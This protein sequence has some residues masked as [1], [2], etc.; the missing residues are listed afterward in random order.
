MYLQEILEV[1]IGVIF[2]WMLLSIAVMQIQEIISSFFAKRSSDLELAIRD[3]LNDPEKVNMFYAHPLIKSLAKPK[4]L[5][6]KDEE[7]AKKLENKDNLTFLERRQLSKLRG[8]PSYIPSAN[9]ASAIFDIVTKAGT[10]ESPIRGITRGM[11]DTI[12]KMKD[13]DREKANAI[14][15]GIYQ[16]GQTAAKSNAGIDFQNGVKRELKSR[17][18]RLGKEYNELT[19][20]TDQLKASIDSPQIDLGALFKSDLV[21]DQLRLGTRVLLNENSALGE[22]I[23]SLFSGVEEYAESADK[24]LALGRKNVETWFDNTMERMNGWYKRWALWLAFGI[25]LMIAILFNVDSLYIAQELWR[26]PAARLASA[27]Y[28]QN[29]VEEKAKEEAKSPTPAS[30]GQESASLKGTRLQIIE[31]ELQKRNFPV[32]W[33]LISF[34]HQGGAYNCARTDQ[35]QEK[36][37]LQTTCYLITNLPKDTWGY[38]SKIFG[39]LITAL[40]ALQGAPFWFD[41]LKKI[42][43][44]RSTGINPIEKPKEG[45]STA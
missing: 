29:F 31:D 21:M 1:V 40:A 39:C 2:A 11:K 16:L 24:A 27:T 26:N 23:N 44:V 15:E 34:P 35:D 43:N 41:T 38:L 4:K 8:R 22:S 12:L 20:Y 14:L 45:T 28:I 42:V 3:M 36:E 17:I 10:E 25:G 18:E 13:G 33:K 19:P 32:G 6:E 7:K 9:F 37:G 5:N 30:D